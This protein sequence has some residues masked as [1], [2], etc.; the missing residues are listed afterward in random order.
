MGAASPGLLRMVLSGARNNL[1]SY[2]TYKPF[3]ASSA[4]HRERNVR[5]VSTETASL[6]S[7]GAE[8]SASSPRP[9]L[10]HAEVRQPDRRAPTRT[11]PHT[12]YLQ[13][14]LDGSPLTLRVIATSPDRL[15]R[16][17]FAGGD[18]AAAP[19]GGEGR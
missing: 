13:A 6:D 8:P 2:G 11:Q 10:S 3:T 15:A 18:A 5:T 12:A 1:R 19:H 9:P 7:G 16:V 17:D 4:T 14:L